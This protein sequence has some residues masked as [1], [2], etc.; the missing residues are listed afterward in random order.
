MRFARGAVTREEA[1]GIIR[2]LMAG[3][4]SCVVVVRSAGGALGQRPKLRPAPVESLSDVELVGVAELARRAFGSPLEA[5]IFLQLRRGPWSPNRLLVFT[6][7]PWLQRVREA[8]KIIQV[9]LST[10]WAVLKCD[11]SEASELCAG[12]SKMVRVV[13]LGTGSGRA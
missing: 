10:G 13:I 7:I 8:E 3:C 6:E 1:R 11:P 5:G 4:P 12:E 2:H 9:L